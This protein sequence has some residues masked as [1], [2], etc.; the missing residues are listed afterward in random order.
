MT[1]KPMDDGKS[2]LSDA[3][4]SVIDRTIIRLQDSL[5]QDQVEAIKQLAA[6]GRCF[7][8]ESLITLADI[9]IEMNEVGHGN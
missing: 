3:A 8:V 1:G 9:T 4:K 2:C 6:E 5:T 7:D